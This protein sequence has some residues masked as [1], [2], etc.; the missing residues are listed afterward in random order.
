MRRGFLATFLCL[1]SLLHLTAC[2][3]TP[4]GA[5]T[6]GVD[7]LATAVAVKLTS[8]AQTLSVTAAVTATPNSAL[9]TPAPPVPAGL[10]VVYV[11][12]GTLWLWASNSSKRLSD[13]GSDDAPLLSDDGQVIA[14]LRAGALWAI[15]ADG[16]QPRPLVTASNGSLPGAFV[17]APNSHLLYY[18][19]EL[20]AGGS[21][22]PQYDL[23][24]VDADHPAPQNLLQ[25][26][27][28]GVPTFAPDGTKIALVQPGKF[29][30]CD[31][32]GSNA[33]TVYTFPP[34]VGP[35]GSSYLP[36][37][38]WMPNGYGF[39]T[40]IPAAQG[41]PNVSTQFVFVPAA[42]GKAAKLGEF[43]A[44]PV[45]GSFPVISPDTDKVASL[46]LQGNDFELHIVDISNTDK[47]IFR[48]PQGRFGLLG[49]APDSLG[50]VYWL[51]DPG[52]A[53]LHTAD[54][55]DLPL[56][57]GALARQ[58]TWLSD[59]TY[60]FLDGSALRVRRLGHPS[61]LIDDGVKSFAAFLP[62]S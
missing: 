26:Q 14:F 49:W 60:L 33:Q 29:I 6:P 45:S 55:R 38:G 17:F 51:D 54:G 36:P 37:L 53:W 56:G 27:Q 34:L 23:N 50:L 4:Q 18:T 30:V 46:R 47:L 61:A 7:R 19:T 10:R 41:T 3:T 13:S 2:G 20:H 5:Q 40:V 1:F 52:N 32:D 21:L 48:Q 24:R 44:A 25:P 22:T 42:G 43:L 31:P 15:N 12:D 39:K 11:K 28:G 35:G 9:T 16:S 57:D 62:A 8:V 58:V 59:D